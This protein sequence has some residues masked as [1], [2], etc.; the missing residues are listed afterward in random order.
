MDK[1]R[2]QTV[3]PTI[4]QIRVMQKMMA[5]HEPTANEI[6]DRNWLEKCVLL[7]GRIAELE[8]MIKEAK[9]SLLPVPEDD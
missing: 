7:A 8:A 6:G 2:W 4:R 3:E 9:E 1:F 5:S